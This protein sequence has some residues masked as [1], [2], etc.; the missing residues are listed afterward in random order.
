MIDEAITPENPTSGK[1]SVS[2]DAES[3]ERSEFPDGHRGLLVADIGDRRGSR[4]VAQSLRVAAR[5]T[6]VF[7]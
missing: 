4:S 6:R 5:I 3:S 2:R 7:V 1:E